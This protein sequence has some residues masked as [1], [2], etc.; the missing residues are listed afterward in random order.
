MWPFENEI[1]WDRGIYFRNGRPSTLKYWLRTHTMQPN[2][3]VLNFLTLVSIFCRSYWSI[4]KAYNNR[5]RQDQG[6][7]S[8][9]STATDQEKNHQRFLQFLYRYT[10]KARKFSKNPFM[11]LLRSNSLKI[12]R[13][14]SLALEEKINLSY[15]QI[16]NFPTSLNKRAMWEHLEP[17]QKKVA[18]Y[19]MSSLDTKI[20][21]TL[22]ESGLWRKNT[23]KT[24]V[25]DT[26]T[27]TITWCLG[28]KK[29]W[30]GC[31][32]NRNIGS[33]WKIYR[34]FS[35]SF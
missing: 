33:Y 32:C 5:I 22:L 29:F 21:R 3:L 19:V 2:L 34:W 16:K 8:D 6:I 4:S 20:K 7:H 30:K 28:H 25:T 15:T 17:L 26:H 24:R 18:M 1:S 10:D 11:L 27:C 23:R 13:K 35:L 12:Q 14:L 9:S 31:M